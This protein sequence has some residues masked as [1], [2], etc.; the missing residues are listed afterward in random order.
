MR[1]KKKLFKRGGAEGRTQKRSA[2]A[3]ASGFRIFC[4]IL[5][6][7]LALA[8]RFLL[9]VPLRSQFGL[10]AREA[11]AQRRALIPLLQLKLDRLALST[12]AFGEGQARIAVVR[13]LPLATCSRAVLFDEGVHAPLRV[14]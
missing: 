9:A 7:E 8:L 12:H 6:L 4:L 3:M 13:L 10:A 1:E 5:E 14:R 2:L 11:V